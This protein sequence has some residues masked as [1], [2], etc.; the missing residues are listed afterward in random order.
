M[1]RFGLVSIPVEAFNAHSAE[2]GQIT[3]HQLH[4]KCHS[5]IQYQKTCPIHGPVPNDEIVSG[6]EVSKGKYIEIDPEELG[7]LRSDAERALTVDTFVKRGEIDSIHFDGRMYY[8]SADGDSARE[9]YTVFLEALRRQDRWGV[10]Q[11]VFSGKQQVV[12]VRPYQDAL[13]MTMLNY[14]A[15]IRD[16]EQTIVP[17][18]TVSGSDRKVKLAEQLIES[19]TDDSFDFS[20]YEDSHRKGLEAL[21]QAKLEGREVVAPEAEE[22][23]EVINLMDALKKSIGRAGR[24]HSH[25]TPARSRRESGRKKGRRAS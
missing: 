25:A 13:L 2:A 18:V 20:K 17:P 23:P 16:P 21:I 12:V 9:P 7:K 5:R 11:V 8:L 15:E 14:D 3:L 24:E 1:L 6:Y 22:A 10:G 4:S 19:W